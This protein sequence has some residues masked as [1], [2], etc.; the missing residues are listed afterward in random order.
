MRYIVLLSSICLFCISCSHLSRS[1]DD[2]RQQYLAITEPG[3]NMEQAVSLIK[4]KIQPEGELQVRTNTPCLD[5]EKPAL[6]KGSASIKVNLGW[7]FWGVTR[8]TTYGEWC[9]NEFDHLVDIVVY[10]SFDDQQ[11]QNTQN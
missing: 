10:K 2:L 1:E 11:L 9:F 3:I 5:R 6:Q 8:T 4:K 7:Y